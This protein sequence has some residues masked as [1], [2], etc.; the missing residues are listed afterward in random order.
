MT[1]L[2]QKDPFDF[3]STCPYLQQMT[4][5]ERIATSIKREIF[6]TKIGAKITE[7][8]QPLDLGPFLKVLKKSGRPMISVEMTSPSTILADIIFKKMQREKVLVLP[9]LKENA[10]KDCVSTAPVMFAS[11]F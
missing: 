3:L 8:Y 9:P 11:A 6:F 2:N 4:S 10:L 5:P 7:K 1:Q